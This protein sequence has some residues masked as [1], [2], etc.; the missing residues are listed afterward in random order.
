MDRLKALDRTCP[1]CKAKAGEP[2]QT[3]LLDG[4]ILNGF[5]AARNLHWKGMPVTFLRIRAKTL[6]KRA[7]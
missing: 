6:D 2:C 1:T 3:V 7:R 5:H 4:D